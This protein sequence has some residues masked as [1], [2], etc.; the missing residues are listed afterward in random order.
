V[1]ASLLDIWEFERGCDRRRAAGAAKA[2]SIAPRFRAQLLRSHGDA[3]VVELAEGQG[4]SGDR[5][6]IFY[7]ERRGFFE[8]ARREEWPSPPGQYG[9]SVL[10]MLTA[11]PA[12]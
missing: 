6:A 12:G 4:P 9:T 11:C 7:L 3:V 10:L 5:S 8:L 2:R 1:R